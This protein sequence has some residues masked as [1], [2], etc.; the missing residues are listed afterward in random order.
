MAVI[1]SFRARVDLIPVVGVG[2]LLMLCVV[3]NDKEGLCGKNSVII[4]T[5][6]LRRCQTLYIN[7]T[8]YNFTKV[9]KTTTI[10]VAAGN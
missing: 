1:E 6:I 10:I 2:R 3:N 4:Q 7:R 9:E 8:Y 5:H